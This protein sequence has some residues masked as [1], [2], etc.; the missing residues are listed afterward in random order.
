MM[1]RYIR[2]NFFDWK[3]LRSEVEAYVRKCIHCTLFNPNT[4]PVF[5]PSRG[6]KANHPTH[7]FQIDIAHM[8]RESAE[9]FNYILKIV[10]VFSRFVILVPT[11]DTT[12]KT[13]ADALYRVF[14]QIGFPKIIGCDNASYFTSE[15][16]NKMKELWGF[17]AQYGPAYVPS[18]QGIVERIG[19]EIGD[20]L[21][22]RRQEFSAD[23]ATLLPG[24]AASINQRK[25]SDTQLSPFE[26][27]YNRPPLFLED[28]SAAF[29]AF[30]E[31][32][33]SKHSDYMRD[34]AVP[35]SIQ[36]REKRNKLAREKLDASRSTGPPLPLGTVVAASFVRKTDAEARF[37]GMYTVIAHKGNGHVLE[38]HL[39]V[40][41]KRVFARHH[42][43]VVDGSYMD[44]SQI[45][46]IVKVKEPGSQLSL[47]SGKTVI[48]ERHFQVLFKGDTV[49]SKEDWYT[50]SMLPPNVIEDYY[51]AVRALGGHRSARVD[52]VLNARRIGAVE[53]APAPSRFAPA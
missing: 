42:L 18:A 30:S 4:R 48:Q 33:W 7:F 15:S 27:M 2:E 36:E 32:E 40:A 39:G 24:V 34:S 6:F 53:S 9:G 37:R 10:C 23:W 25:S 3:S 12:T 20:L 1:L 43:K 14:S 29:P 46:R 11:R 26:I 8:D 28:Y 21:N 22:I 16:F 38:D 52:P 35:F 45:D 51:Q 17:D 47:P 44:L 50:A 31:A 13:I 41:V 19:R 5:L 49:A